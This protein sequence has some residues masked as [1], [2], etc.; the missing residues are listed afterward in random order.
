MCIRVPRSCILVVW[1]LLLFHCETFVFQVGETIQIFHKGR[2]CVGCILSRRSK[3]Q[4][5]FVS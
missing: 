3:V 1:V 5:C 4:S 2:E